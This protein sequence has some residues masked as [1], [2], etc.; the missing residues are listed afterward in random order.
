[1]RL[2]SSVAELPKNTFNTVIV[3]SFNHSGPG[4]PLGFFIPDTIQRATAQKLE[5]AVLRN[6]NAARDF[7]DVRDIVS[8][9]SSLLMEDSLQHNVYN[10]CSGEGI[11]NLELYTLIQNR[12]SKARGIPASNNIQIE[13]TG[14]EDRIIGDNSR[15]V[16]GLSWKRNVGIEESIDDYLASASV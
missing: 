5:P 16:S 10:V 11:T 6:A 15:L 13:N 2:E 1:M 7:L 3:R 9:Y 12:L 8:A 14:Y 4:Q